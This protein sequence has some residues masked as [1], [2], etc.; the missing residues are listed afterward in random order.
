M[1]LSD[2]R[3][4]LVTGASS[5]IG[6]AA[7]RRLRR[8]G[9]EVHAVARRVDKL[10]KLALETGCAPHVLDLTDTDAL[11]RELSGLAVD[12][13]VNNAGL[14][15]GFGPLHRAER[16]DI[17][18]TFQTN[19]VAFA[20]VLRAVLPGMVER[21]CGHVFNIG[22]VAG[23]Y[24]INSPV[25]GGS[26][27]AVH[28]MSMNLRMD[29]QGSGVRVTEICPGRVDTPFFEVA[30]EDAQARARFMDTGT[31]HMIPDDVVDAIQYALDA[32]WRVNVGR[33]EITPTEQ[34]LGGASLT[35]VQR[36]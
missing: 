23:L 30:L 4:A 19:V 27:G 6:E 29:L 32:P 2:Y 5:G 33:I 1:A 14:G 28:L 21:R 3:S 16:E 7:V 31:E 9:L 18:V 24:A 25:Y 22:S 34:V 11:Y 35:P 10:E 26:K 36:D 12:V 17:D 8:H 13:V 15:R 20:H